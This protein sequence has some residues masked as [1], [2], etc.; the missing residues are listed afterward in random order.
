MRAVRVGQLVCLA[1]LLA[2]S[3][4]FTSDGGADTF[5]LRNGGQVRG[6]WLNRD[7]RPIRQYLIATEEGGRLRLDAAQVR[8]A[9]TQSEAAVEYERRAPQTAGTVEAQWALAEWCREHNLSKPRQVHLQRILDLDPDH[10]GA[11]RGLGYSQIGGRWVT[12]PGIQERRGLELSN[13]R[14][15]YP[16]EIELIE[17]QQTTEQKQRE[18]MLRLKRWRDLLGTDKGRQTY[19]EIR[20]VRDPLAVAPLGQLLQLE[21]RRDVKTLYIEVLKDIGNEDAVLTLLNTSL[22]D[23]DEEIYHTCVDQLVKLK[24]PRI[25]AQYVPYLK[26]KNNVRLNRAAQALGRLEDK[27]VISP[28]IDA[29]VSTH[30]IVLPA[31]N[32]DAYTASFANPSAGT[33]LGATPVSS[34]GTPGGTGFSAGGEAKV[35]PRT[36]PNQDVLDALIRLSGGVN[37]GFEPRAWRSWLANENRK[38]TPPLHTRRDPE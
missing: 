26:D 7:E 14:W 21:S 25:A 8:Q 15:R 37:F 18:W 22:Q 13:G 38:A 32:P 12:P 20:A 28:L 34:P 10:V 4:A 30:Y 33:P 9:V 16:Q 11:R 17:R 6:R 2:T 35:I 3:G 19:E 31:P 29:L 24:P 36:V 5:I 27:S 1:L 23:L